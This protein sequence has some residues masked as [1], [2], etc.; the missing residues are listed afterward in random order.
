MNATSYNA[1]TRMEEA[2]AKAAGR[3]FLLMRFATHPASEFPAISGLDLCREAG[4]SMERRDEWR[5]GLGILDTLCCGGRSTPISRR[6]VAAL[7]PGPPRA[8]VEYPLASQRL[9]LCIRRCVSGARK[10]HHSVFYHNKINRL[11]PD[12]FLIRD[13]RH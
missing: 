5:G 13:L 3:R 8:P 7:P 4:R 9:G 1:F 11:R 10:R 6:L 2:M 12:M